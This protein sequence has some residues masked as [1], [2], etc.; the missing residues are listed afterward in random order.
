MSSYLRYSDYVISE[1]FSLNVVDGSW[2]EASYVSL[3]QVG[4]TPMIV[5]FATSGTSPSGSRH[6]QNHGSFVKVLASGNGSATVSFDALDYQSNNV[7]AG[8]GISPTKCIVFRIDNFEL[9]T[10]RVLDMKLWS[11]DLGDFL[12][13][14]YAKLLYETSS[15]WVQN[16]SISVSDLTNKDKWVPESLPDIQ[17]VLRASGN[18]YTIWDTKDEH[19]SQ[20]IYLALAASGN[21][22][23]GEYGSTG[24][25]ATGF[26]IRITYDYDNLEPLRD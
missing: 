5:E 8:S 26:R 19:S 15:T 6:L 4:V 22:P 20:Y 12:Y 11:P 17:N 13:P 25:D 18:G 14:Q 1:P 2:A 7:G 10:T 21:T 24:N 23:L 16:K 3:S 9:D